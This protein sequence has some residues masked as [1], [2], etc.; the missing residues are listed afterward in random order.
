L[1]SDHEPGVLTDA[2]GPDRPISASLILPV[3]LCVAAYNLLLIGV[4]APLVLTEPAARWMI[5]AHLAALALPFLLS[6]ASR[7]GRAVAVLRDVYPVLWLCVFWKELGIHHSIVGSAAGDALVSRLDL[8]LFGGHPN[9]HWM[10]S[11]PALWFSELMHSFYFAYYPLVLL[12]PLMVIV[13]R[14][15]E[16]RRDVL[17]RVTAA[18]LTCFS[19]YAVLPAAGPMHTL[20]VYSGDLVNGLFY[21]LTHLARQGGD[22]L[23][24]AFP[25]SHV[26]GAVT[27]AWLTCRYWGG[28]QGKAATLTAVM[29]G[30]ATVYTQNH[31][32][33][34]AVSGALIA[35]T[36]HNLVIP[37][38]SAREVPSA[39]SPGRTELPPLGAARQAAG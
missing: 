36:L 4:W 20:P 32:L 38:T 29:I 10:P 6:N 14:G 23:G 37:R 24:T 28:W 12:V 16:E 2:V 1:A 25:S 27:S 21:Q 35:L 22:A 3:D 5:G 31:F 9:L 13:R 39:I 26:V 8:R 17:L 30:L 7:R 15:A 19:V 11:M 18:Y 34:D 33:V